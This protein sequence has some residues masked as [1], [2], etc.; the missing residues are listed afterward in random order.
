MKKYSRPPRLPRMSIAQSPRQKLSNI[1]RKITNL[2]KQH[3]T[4]T[5]QILARSL[6]Y[7]YRQ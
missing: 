1:E 4:K 5:T 2:N 7:F 3:F 6:A